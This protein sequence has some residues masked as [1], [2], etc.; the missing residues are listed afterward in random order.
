MADDVKRLL[1]QFGEPVSRAAARTLGIE[2]APIGSAH[3]R[4]PF[5]GHL[6][7]GID[8]G[9]LGRII[10]AA[11]AGQSQEWMILAEEI[12]ELFPHYA[13]VLGKRRRQVAQLPA[14]VIAAP[15][16]NRTIERRYEAH[17]QFVR[18]WLDEG[19]LADA[20]WD[21]T[22]AI[23]K[24]YSAAEIIWRQ[25][26]ER[27][28]P[29]RIVYV[30][31]QH[32]E[33]SYE[34]G[35]TLWLRSERGFET[36]SPLKWLAHRHPAKSGAAIRSG[37]TRMV[38]FMW[39]YASYTQRD[40]QTF[41]QGYGLPLRLGRYGPEASET[42][43]RVLWRAVQSIA[44]DVAAI[45]PK[46]MEVEFVEP[47]TQSVSALFDARADWLNFEVSKLVLG[48]TAG[49]DAVRGSHAVGR[50]HRAVE[51]DV[52]RYDAGLLAT[53]LTRQI[54]Q[55]MIALTFGPQAHYPTLALGRPDEVP[56]AELVPALAALG[57]LGLKVPVAE[58]LERLQLR[59][60]EGEE[61]TIGGM[62]TPPGV[63]VPQEPRPDPEDSA[64]MARLLS[65]RR[66]V[67]RRLLA[68]HAERDEDT[69]DRLTGRMAQD[70]QGALAGLTDEV[71][72]AVEQA[73]DLPDLARRLAALRL[74]ERAFAEALA[75]GM[76]LAQLVGQAELLDQLDWRGLSP[77]EIE[78]RRRG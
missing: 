20:L 53:T 29:E 61:E 24:G 55:P 75:R 58:I 25:E 6:A 67:G 74:D 49:T 13:A 34:D 50:E 36:L 73:V 23:G 21:M 51:Q 62:A 7:F 54:V 65:D 17:A 8:P 18:D 33:I 57:P 47:K 10:R 71:R 37:L 4:P 28:V 59:P 16:P 22:D 15:A 1:D 46:S 9:R 64:A 66:L 30:A 68:R 63:V 32:F 69:I 78:G 19:V 56:L 60:A 2:T 38:A 77:R 27:V 26:P 14:A 39:L 42:D 3:N 52:E 11:D 70:A 12:E 76:A 41:I 48:S 43:K 5:I 45:V 44:G 40:W 31:P 35:K 72:A